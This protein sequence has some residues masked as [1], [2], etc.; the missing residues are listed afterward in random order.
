VSER[1]NPTLIGAFLLGAIALVVTGLMVFGGGRFFTETVTYVAYFPE[2]VSGL[3]D[4]APVNFRGVKVGAVRRIEVQ[5]D[6]QDLSVKIPVYLQLERRRIREIGGTIPEVDF[7]PELIERGLRAQLQLQ[8]IVTGQLSVQLDILPD[9][10]ARYVGP[11]GEFPEMP[12]IPSSMQEFTETLESLS[13]QDLV[14]DARQVLA[15]LRVLVNSPELAELLTGVNEFVN[16]GELLGVIAHT[17]E[18]ID[19]VQALVSNIDGRVGNLSTSAELTFTE[20]NETLGGVQKTLVAARQ[21][22]SIAA[23][24]S[25]MRYEFE[26]MLGELTAAARSIRL[27]AEYLERNPDALVRGKPGGS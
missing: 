20:V 15:G 27:L 1:A 24:G 23:E 6:A 12:T 10:P 21:S 2:T 22:L 25:P 3:N 13:I 7:I 14:N 11:V 4:G 26:K 8:S 16:S 18:A 5:L 19:D 17:N 9:R